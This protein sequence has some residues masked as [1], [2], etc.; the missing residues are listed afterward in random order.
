MSR[1]IQIAPVRKSIV[2]T[3]S[4]EHAFHV[5]TAKIDNWWPRGHSLGESALRESNIEPFVGGRWYSTHEDG[6]ERTIGHILEWEPPARFV[7]TWEIN[8]NWG[9]EPRQSFASE[10]EVNFIAEDDGRTRVEL[11]HRHFER[12][13]DEAGNKMRDD[14]KDGWPGLLELY[15]S[16]VDK[17]GNSQGDR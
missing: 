2:V 17:I 16:E 1:K 8:A 12:M 3:A 4:P 11:E 9:S 6:E 14:V 5:F 7:V 10:V 15:A 13:G